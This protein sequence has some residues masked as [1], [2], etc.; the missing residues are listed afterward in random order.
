MSLEKAY[1][2]K[3]CEKLEK[4]GW[5]EL[6]TQ[7]LVNHLIKDIFE[8]KIEELNKDVLD[9]YPEQKDKI[10][11]QVYLAIQ[12]ADEVKMLDILRFGADIIIKRWNSLIPLNIK[13]ID[14]ENIERNEF[15][16]IREQ[17]VKH[18]NKIDRPDI[19]LFV[20]G[21]PIVLI[22]G[23]SP[24]IQSFG[25]PY[26][27]GLKQI[28]RYQ[29]EIRSLFKFV[30]FGVA[31]ADR[32]P[33][34]P[35]FPR[36]EIKP[37]SGYGFWKVNR[38]ENI[39]DLLKPDRLLDIVRHFIFFT[40][41]K[42]G[43][44]TKIMA[45]YMQYFA[46]KQ[47]MKR[48]SKYL[49]NKDNK[50]QGLV[51]HWQGSGKTYTM[52]FIAYQFLLNY[53]K[54]NPLVF[55][56][57]DRIELE[58][59][60]DD[61]FK[62]I[63]HKR[64]GDVKRIE[65]IKELK[66]V[67]KNA[68]R[69]WGLKITTI[70]KFQ[71]KELGIKEK[72]GKKEVLF[73]ID[74]AHRSQ[75]GDL[76]ASMR[77]IFSSGIFIGFTGTPVFV[78][79]RNTFKHF[80]YP[81]EGEIYL[82]VYFIQQSQEDGFTLPIIFRV[83]EEKKEKVGGINILLS[84]D[85]IKTIL[86]GY[87]K[88]E[89]EV[90]SILEGGI[91]RKIKRQLRDKIRKTRVILE[92]E[93]R[94]EKVVEYIKKEKRIEKDTENFTF[95]AMIV[96]ANRIACVRY[97][98]IMDRY[99]PEEFS[100]VV[101]SYQPN[102]KEE[103]HAFKE[104]F[105]KR[106]KTRDWN[107]ANEKVRENF[108]KKEYPKVLIVTDM[109]LTGF[110]APILKVMY[111]DK[112]MFYHRLLQATARVNRPYSELNKKHGLIVDSVGLLSHIQRTLNIYQ[113]LAEENSEK[114]KEDLKNVFKDSEKE[115]EILKNKIDYLKVKLKDYE[116]DLEVISKC[117]ENNDLG[118]Y[119]DLKNKIGY[120]TLSFSEKED[121]RKTMR[122]VKEALEIYKSLGAYPG[123]LKYKWEKDALFVIYDMF[124]KIIRKGKKKITREV[125]DKLIEQIHKSTIV[126][127]IMNRFEKEIKA[128]KPMKPQI[129][130]ASVTFYEVRNVVMDKLHNPL[131]REIYERL[132]RLR[133]MWLT[134]NIDVEKFI[135][136][137][138]YEKKEVDRLERI[139]Q[140]PGWEKIYEM[141][142][143]YLQKKLSKKVEINE[144]KVKLKD[145]FKRNRFLETDEKEVKLIVA[146]TLLKLR[147][148]HKKR[149]EIEAKIAEMI[150]NEIRREI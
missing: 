47:V 144:L 119:D 121:I 56:V 69:E 131:Y 19:L 62:S 143:E 111:L 55:F 22:E 73:L 35:T 107:E 70:Q 136:G 86:E 106:Y 6:K 130:E 117:L 30:Q 129:K 97:K 123:K 46:T 65:D 48:I 23:K 91:A 76:A 45:R 83:I 78:N 93:K 103:I 44:R 100:E 63:E 99:F 2:D 139:E 58:K 40:R 60:L 34:I 128:V 118:F 75:Y 127:D 147:M 94:I 32:N 18:G 57:I 148:D 25:D 149:Q 68:E 71:P 74:E 146:K 79:E 24:I 134:R 150:I 84:E 21:I 53:H 7:D 27:E 14:Y 54:R 88:D 141:T 132:E 140:K 122:F 133:K 90:D 10:M 105:L 108:L 17:E 37:P 113:Y 49:E 135:E 42:K 89:A 102:E 137:L 126:E 29:K 98:K 12:N 138:E 38:K 4:I 82:D 1:L 36:E 81:K 39:F 112:P 33:Y 80:A 66:E 3:F 77:N 114:I 52:F 92:N 41:D 109:L 72:V 145:I 110:D 8:K 67:I 116:I 9:A 31:V 95:K 13:L 50:N 104:E 142:S 15:H 11:S 16:C 20:N 115:L 61:V 59:Q 64:F 96:A 85:E 43:E 51:W 101:M 28:M 125:W 120:I 5:K 124:L 87:K 26:Y